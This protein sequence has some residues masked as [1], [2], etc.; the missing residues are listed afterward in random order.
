MSHTVKAI[1]KAWEDTSINANNVAHE[2]LECFHHPNFYNDNSSVQREMGAY[3]KSWIEGQSAEDKRYILNALTKD[4]V[5]NGKNK[6]KGHE[7]DQIGHGC[8]G[9]ELGAGA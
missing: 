9:R 7:K 4:S 1:V 8:G 2:V 6:R 5:R 3:L